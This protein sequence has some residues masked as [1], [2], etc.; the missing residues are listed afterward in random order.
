M[1][2]RL[3]VVGTV[4]RSRSATEKAALAAEF[5]DRLLPR[6]ETAQIRPVI[7]R[8]FP[9]EAAADAHRYL[10]ENRSFGKVVLEVGRT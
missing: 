5:R 8:S 7:D 3:M 9:L 1:R 2:G 10:E 6:F 4:L